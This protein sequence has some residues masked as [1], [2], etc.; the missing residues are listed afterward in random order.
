MKYL[1]TENQFH[2][3]INKVFQQTV[4]EIKNFC[5][6]PYAETFPDW[7]GFD[8]C[9]QINIIEKIEINNIEKE[10]SKSNVLGEKY[11][12]FIVWV[13]IY[14]DTTRFY[15][16]DDL[17]FTISDRIFKKYKIRVN[18]RIQEEINTNTNPNW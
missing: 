15:D 11:P 1:I 17:K 8:D 2:S 3:T 7:L 6:V 5:E 9:D 16:F 14:Y 4:N 18:V 13:K 10:K 12:T